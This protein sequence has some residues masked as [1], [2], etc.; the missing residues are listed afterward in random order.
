M[1]SVITDIV[2]IEPLE[3]NL[4]PNPIQTNSSFR[5]N[6]DHLKEQLQHS[7]R[8]KNRRKILF[9]YFCLGKWLEDASLR[10]SQR[11]DLRNNISAY[12]YTVAIRTYRV[13]EFHPE[14]IYRTKTLTI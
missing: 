5:E 14:Q 4:P 6:L 2:E 8:L 10:K 1:E 11:L 13:F 7:S 9:Y 12:Q 3:V